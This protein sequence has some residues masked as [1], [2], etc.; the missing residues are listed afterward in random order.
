[1]VTGTGVSSIPWD[2]PWRTKL[3]D[4]LEVIVGQLEAVGIRDI[5]IGGSFL[6][7]K[8]HPNDIDGYFFCSAR[9]VFSG[10]LARKL[11]GLDPHAAWTWNPKNAK[12]YRGGKKRRLP[13]WHRYRIDM[14]AHWGDENENPA[15]LFRTTRNGEQ[16]GIIKIRGTP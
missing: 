14:H 5:Y 13:L 8:A 16:R 3:V 4:H 7:D 12:P 9:E 6:E 10:E 1:L 2:Q 11:N 15:A